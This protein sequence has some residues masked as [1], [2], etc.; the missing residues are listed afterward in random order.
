MLTLVLDQ[1][2]KIWAL[3]ALTPGQPRDLLGPVL[4]LNLIR[5]PGAAFSLGDSVTWLLTLVALGIVV[6]VGRAATRVGHGGWAVTLGM[7]LGGAIGNLID[8]ILRAPGFG[9][10]HVVDF[11]DYFGLFIGNVADIAIVV[12]AAFGA[13]LALRGIPLEGVTHG[14]H[15][16]GEAH[17]EPE[18]GAGDPHV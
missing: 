7:L 2:S 3:D 11:I 6:W 8:R 13:V 17:P 15:E 10:G 4:R 5:N 9:R 16:A 14:R 18:A 12:A 1:G